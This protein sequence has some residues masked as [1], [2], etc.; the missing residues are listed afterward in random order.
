MSELLVNTIKKADGTGSLSVPAESGTVVTTASPSLGR[1]NLIING[2]MQVA[3]RGT[4]GTPSNSG[5]V[6]DRFNNGYSGL[7]GTLTTSQETSVVPEGFTTALKMSMSASE[8]SLDAGDY[9]TVRQVIEAQN[10]QHL[11][12]GTSNA[13]ELTASFWVRSS[14]ASTYTA[15]LYQQDSNLTIGKTFTID[16]ADTWE[17]KTLTFAANTTGTITND[18]G[19]GLQLSIWVDAGSNFTSGTFSTD[20]QTNNNTER[21]YAT[22][23]WL[24]STSPTFYWT[25]VQLEVGS[26]ATPFEH[27]SYGEELALCQRYFAIVSQKQVNGAQTNRAQNIGSIFNSTRVFTK[28]PLQVR[29]RVNPTVTGTNI[30]GTAYRDGAGASITALSTVYHDVGTIGLD[31]LVSGQ[32]GGQACH[33][34]LLGDSL[35]TADAEL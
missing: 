35:I 3:Q 7:D 16:A 8:A 6:L 29:M 2:A 1:R 14:V 24:E 25:G 21:V 18:S 17:Y 4:S 11:K 30:S 28:M 33:I 20:W 9:I 13:V 15:E 22:T 5:Y 31:F 12:Y 10:L 26:V 32:S 27:R 34:D 23:G 19:N